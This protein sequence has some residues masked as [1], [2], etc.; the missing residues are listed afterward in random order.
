MT[1]A[2][3]RPMSVVAIDSNFA[4]ASLVK[5]TSILQPWSGAFLSAVAVEIV[6]P[7]ISEGP[8]E[9]QRVAWPVYENSPKMTFCPGAISPCAGPGCVA[10]ASTAR[11]DWRPAAGTGG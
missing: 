1:I 3:L 6:G 5:V 4:L 2:S 11:H 7:A 8:S 10:S 9:K